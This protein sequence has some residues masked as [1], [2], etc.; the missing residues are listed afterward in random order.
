MQF[1]IECFWEINMGREVRRVAK[2]WE[3]PK[4][5]LTGR[6]KPLFPYSYYEES[7]EEFLT[8]LVKNGLQ[9]AIYE[10]GSAPDINDYM[11]NWDNSEATHYMMYETT[12]EGT[13]ISP[14]F[15]TPEEVARWLVDNNASA[16]A[17][18]TATY[19]A[20]LRV[21]NGG[22]AVSAVYTPDNGLQSGVEAMSNG[23]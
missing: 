4:N 18:Q 6:Y 17:D 1:L 23:K 8:E 2:N 22:F 20:W 5:E 3:H 15:E 13:P 9:S 14:A 12:S 10:Y 7:K 16:F 21:A 19:E 11:P